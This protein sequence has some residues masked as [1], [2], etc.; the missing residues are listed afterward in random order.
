MCS[1]FL[2]S[3]HASVRSRPFESSCFLS[4]G[5][6]QYGQ[7]LLGGQNSVR[8]ARSIDL[9]RR[10]HAF[11]LEGSGRILNEGDV[12]AQ[13]HAKARGGFDAGV[14]YHANEDDV[15]DPPLCELG[16][17][18]GIGEAALPQCSSTTTSPSRGPNSGWNAPP[19]L[20]AAKPWLWFARIW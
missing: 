3:V 8:E 19:Q 17:E 9:V 2:A 11:P 7:Q 15:L 6:R 16:V 18:I 12:V 4:S 14:R 5:R 1:L 20:P 13:F 10:V